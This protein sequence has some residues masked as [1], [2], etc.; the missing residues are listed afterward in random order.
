MEEDKTIELDEMKTI[1]VKDGHSTLRIK[2]IKRITDVYGISDKKKSMG[3]VLKNGD[4]NLFSIDVDKGEIWTD[5]LTL[6]LS[7]KGMKRLL[8]IIDD[9]FGEHEAE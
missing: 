8:K 2:E 9:I 1:E 7:E 5:I 6:K 3:Y 4:N